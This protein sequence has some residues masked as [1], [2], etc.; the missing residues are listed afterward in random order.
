M[1]EG[2]SSSHKRA[3][4]VVLS[5][6]MLSAVAATQFARTDLGYSFSITGGDSGIRFI[7]HDDAVDAVILLRADNADGSNLR[8]ELGD[9]ARGQTVIYTG[10][11]GIVNENQYGISITSVSL[12]GSGGVHMFMWLH[13]NADTKATEDS[14]TLIFNDGAG[15][16]PFTWL[17]GP[18]NGNAADANGIATPLDPQSHTRTLTAN[19]NAAN[20]DH[21]WL[22]M[23]LLIPEAVSNGQFS[24]S[25][26]F[27]FIETEEALSVT[28][29]NGGESWENGAVQ[30]IQWLGLDESAE[31]VKLEYSK[32]EFVS[33]VNTIVASTPNDG[34]YSWTVPNDVDASVWVRVSD[35][36]QPSLNDVSDA[37]FAIIASDSN[38]MAHWRF[39]E[40]S[41]SST[42]D[43]TA[44]DNDGTLYDGATFSSRAIA[45]SSLDAI[46]DHSNV[47]VAD[48]ATLDVG[49]GSYTYEA[50]FNTVEGGNKYI[51]KKKGSESSETFLMLNGDEVKFRIKDND[52][53][54]VEI[55]HNSDYADG[56]WHHVVVVVNQNDNYLYLYLDGSNAVTPKSITSIGDVSNDGQLIIGAKDSSGGDEF[57]GYLDEM[58]FYD[59]TLSPSEIS[60]KYAEWPKTL[61]LSTPNGGEFLDQGASSTIVW[62]TAGNIDYTKLEYSTDNFVSDI[63]TIVASTDNDGSHAWT[64]PTITSSTVKVRVS[65]ASDATANIVSNADFTITDMRHWWKLD[66]SSGTDAADSI[67]TEDGALYDGATWST[68]GKLNN[69]L[70]LDGTDDYVKISDDNT[71]D[72]YSSDS[73]SLALW[74][75]ADTGGSEQ[76]L[77]NK[78]YGEDNKYYMLRLE[79]TGELYTGVGDGD[80]AFFQTTGTY[81]DATWHHA[82]VVIDR[83]TD[84]LILY[85]DGSEAGYASITAV[86]GMDQG[87][88]LYLGTQKTTNYFDGLMDEFLFY[89]YALSSSEVSTLYSSY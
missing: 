66:E 68:S 37:S 62:N 57:Q 21:V 31:N 70:S 54:Y 16:Q 89:N 20:T 81:D 55:K 72:V 58:R 63:N 7:G 83:A 80:A 64:V 69:A 76:Y 60:A 40:G 12:T 4:L 23:K 39:D 17:L 73:V 77:F 88:H 50:W 41:G 1:T 33:D 42:L 2:L 65:D 48:S 32:D 27:N 19:D 24:G 44:N 78:G 67:G 71:I 87:K 53:D 6:L 61:T 8:L 86:G 56:E 15:P 13:N 29:P 84:K 34:S 5:L 35:T 10:A 79:S 3:T 11:F 26:S 9:W 51:F 75:K 14:G 28:S 43:S 18:G 74:F 59:R 47:V 30:N 52:G 82:V 49:T 38:L 22:Q 45:S 25:I 36:T 46:V 85:V